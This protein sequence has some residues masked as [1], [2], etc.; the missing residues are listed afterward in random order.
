M[1]HWSHYLFSW[2]NPTTTRYDVLRTRCH[3]G[4]AE[5]LRGRLSAQKVALG[6]VQAT[7]SIEQGYVVLPALTAPWALPQRPN[8]WKKT[9]LVGTP[10]MEWR[11]CNLQASLLEEQ[12]RISLQRRIPRLLGQRT[13]TVY[14]SLSPRSTERLLLPLLARPTR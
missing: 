5:L 2:I 4:K 11:V 8:P 3:L 6:G 14:D 13:A 12:R 10:K 7:Q 1:W 9:W